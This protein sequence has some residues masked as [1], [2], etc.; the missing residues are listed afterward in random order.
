[1]KKITAIFLVTLFAIEAQSQAIEFGVKAGINLSSLTS[2]PNLGDANTTTGLVFG[3]FARTSS[4]GFFMQPEILFTQRKGVF[5][6]NASKQTV[7]NTLTYIDVPLL[8]GYKIAVFRFN[9]GPNLQF[10][11]AAN[12]E[13]P[14]ILNDPN[15]SK[16]NFNA[17][18]VGMQLGVGVN[19]G[20]IN[21][22]ARYDGSIGDLG[23]TITTSSG[24]N[25]NYSTRANMFQLTL[26]YRIL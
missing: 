24:Q 23:K 15:F 5:T 11:M 25:I 20:K 10:L 3:A 19:L 1:M 8:L 13:A 26:G 18:S 12:Q 7:T 2:A 22:D 21:L 9:A 6:D 14:A 16:N 4:A 17:F